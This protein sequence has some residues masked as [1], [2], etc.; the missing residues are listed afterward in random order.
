[1]TLQEYI[2]KNY[3]VRGTGNQFLVN[4]RTLKEIVESLQGNV[5]EGRTID[6]FP[7]ELDTTIPDGVIECR[8][9]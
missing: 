5:L 1:M 2:R 9:T 7:F 4:E 3:V 8:Q 6:E